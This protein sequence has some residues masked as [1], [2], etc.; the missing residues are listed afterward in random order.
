MPTVPVP[1][2]T[3][4]PEPED[5]FERKL[6]GISLRVNTLRDLSSERSVDRQ[7]ITREAAATRL[8]ELFEED[9]DEI[10]KDQRLYTTIGVIEKNTDL[11]ELSLGLYSEGVLGFYLRDED[12]LYVV[13]DSG[14]L[15]PANERTYVHEFV[16]ALQEQHFD[17]HAT[18]ESIDGNSDATGALRALLEGD[19]T[20]AESAYILEFLD[21]AEREASQPEISSALLEALRAA[22]HILRRGYAFPYL[23]GARFVFAIFRTGGWDAIDQA[24]KTIPQSTE[25][26]LHPQRYFSGDAPVEVHP[27]DLA[28]GLGDGWTRV[29]RDTMGEF[30]LLTYLETDLS[31]ENASLAADGWGGDTYRLFRGPKDENLLVMDI[32]WDTAGDAREFFDLFSEFTEARTGSTW[33]TPAEDQTA[34]LMVLADQ[35][36]FISLHEAETQ[37]VFAPDDATLQNVLT[38]ITKADAAQE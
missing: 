5:P 8:G 13:K 18:F 24:Y 9:R 30:F 22:P 10:A 19:A 36:I 38:T 17:S 31:G 2:A 16:H 33:H 15:T 7:F 29:R 27:P 1:T 11:F 3:P 28:E 14:E 20:L 37:V 34:R 26:I 21:E 25:H 32:V 12:K 6:E 23:E 35:H 4:P